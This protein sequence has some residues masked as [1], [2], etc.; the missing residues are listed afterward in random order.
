M[1]WRLDVLKSLEDQGYEFEPEAM[2]QDPDAFDE[3]GFPLAVRLDP[4]DSWSE[5]DDPSAYAMVLIDD[6]LRLSPIRQRAE[7]AK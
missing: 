4:F 5:H 2:G 3:D 6:Y 7:G 1:E